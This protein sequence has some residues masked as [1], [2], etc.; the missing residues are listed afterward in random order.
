MSIT[1]SAQRGAVSAG[2]PS[3]PTG[4]NGR[5]GMPLIVTLPRRRVPKIRSAF[6]FRGLIFQKWFTLN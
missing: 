1:S 4:K 5:A 2:A 3:D 6:L